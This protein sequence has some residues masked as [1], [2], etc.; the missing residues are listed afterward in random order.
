MASQPRPLTLIV[1]IDF[2]DLSFQALMVAKN[3]ADRCQPSVVHAVYVVPQIEMDSPLPTL[4][5]E[6]ANEGLAR[7]QQYLADHKLTDL[8]KARA[9]VGSASM[10][11]PE[12]ARSIHADVIVLGTHGRKGLARLVMGSVAESVMREAPCSVLVVRER[13]LGPEEL[14]QPARPGQDMHEHHAHGHTHNEGPNAATSQ[15]GMGALTFRA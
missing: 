12:I 6:L 1:G 11:L 9:A 7:L 8:V 15:Y 14:I 3:L 13:E 4:R 2:S 5:A 10:V